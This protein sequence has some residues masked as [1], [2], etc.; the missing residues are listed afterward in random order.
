MKHR[1]PILLALGAT[2]ALCVSCRKSCT[3]L[4]YNGTSHT[5]SADEVDDHGGSCSGM[6]Y[7]YTPGS[8]GADNRYY[9]VC[10]WD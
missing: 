2:L 8:S 9:T 3:C 7:M 6:E 5:Y 10:N 4:A 1:I